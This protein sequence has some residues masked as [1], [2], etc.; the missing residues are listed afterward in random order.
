MA[1]L[2]L[3]CAGERD[4]RELAATGADRAHAIHRHDY[5]TDAL[6]R[7]VSSAATDGV[8]LRDPDEEIGEILRRFSGSE[9]D[10]VITTDDYPGSTLASVVAQQLGLPGVDP[11]VDLGCQHKYWSRVAQRAAAP[12]AVPWFTRAGADDR[13]DGDECPGFPAFVKPVKSF[14][15]IGARRVDSADELRRAIAE[16]PVPPAFLRPFDRLL[17]TFA[18]TTVGPPLIVEG[19]LT[20]VQATL[21]GFVCDGQVVVIGVVDSIM[22]PGTLSFQ[23]FEYPSSLPHAVQRRM[24][25]VATAVMTSIGFD[26]GMFNIELMHDPATGSVHIIEINPRMSSQFADLYEKVDGFNPYRVL[27]DVA[28]G[29]EPAIA[30]RRGRYPMA[31]SCVL[32]T[33]ADHCVVRVPRKRH[34]AALVRRYPGLRVEILASEGTRLSHT[35]QDGH[36]FRYGLINVGGEDRGA[37]LSAFEDCRRSLPFVLLPVG[38]REQDRHW[39][40][41]L[42][43]LALGA[44]G[45]R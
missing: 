40:R 37:I 8:A 21:D 27:V 9:L 13:T 26:N 42:G 32:R 2:L 35:M 7:L 11:V 20:G 22:F 4:L 29:R 15:S 43:G 25:E 44:D 30:S 10:G 23:R 41:A 45:Q 18:G 24:A 36:S 3:L 1:N 14:F 34:V 5:G 6:E 33:F 12:D 39:P 38:C 31:A 19:L 28:T 17:R 16:N